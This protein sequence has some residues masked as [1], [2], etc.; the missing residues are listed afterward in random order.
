MFRFAYLKRKMSE[1]NFYIHP[2]QQQYCFE[3]ENSARFLEIMLF[4][5]SRL[6][7]EMRIHLFPSFPVPKAISHA[8][9][10]RTLV[11]FSMHSSF[12]LFILLTNVLTLLVYLL[13]SVPPNW[14]KNSLRREIILYY[15]YL[16]YPHTT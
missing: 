15:I 13:I 4:M 14:S 3:F 11:P 7:F 8:L 2:K 6:L 12:L 9:K 10:S 16:F 1:D 5:K